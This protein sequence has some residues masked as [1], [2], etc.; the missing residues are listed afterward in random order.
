MPDQSVFIELA[1]SGTP[2][3]NIGQ[4]TPAT[5]RKLDALVKAGKLIKN[6]DYWM[7]LGHLRPVWTA[8]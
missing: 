3:W 4:L 7:G 2:V 6:Q 5:K 1:L 8:A